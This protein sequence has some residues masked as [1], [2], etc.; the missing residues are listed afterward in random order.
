MPHRCGTGLDYPRGSPRLNRSRKSVKRPSSA[1]HKHQEAP[2]LP[3]I[4]DK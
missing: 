1:E 2:G 4:T 3:Q